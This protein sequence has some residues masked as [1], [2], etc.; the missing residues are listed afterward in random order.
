MPGV[1]AAASVDVTSRTLELEA[2]PGLA[3]LVHERREGASLSSAGGSRTLAAAEERC[4]PVLL[5][6]P[7]VEGGLGPGQEPGPKWGLG[8]DGVGSPDAGSLRSSVFAQLG[9]QLAADHGM[10][11]VQVGWR[12]PPRSEGVSRLEIAATD[13]LLAMNWAMQRQMERWPVEGAAA[14][15]VWLAGFGFGGGAAVMCADFLAA[16]ASGRGDS[17]GD[18]ASWPPSASSRGRRC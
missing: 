4:A 11:C 3:L 13:L 12:A 17:G 16:A 2:A 8:E 5:M 10:L 7:D 18:G 14:P 1:D 6:A 15:R 9:Q